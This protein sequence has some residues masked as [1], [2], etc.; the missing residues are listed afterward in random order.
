MAPLGAVAPSCPTLAIGAVAAGCGAGS[1]S[2]SG[3]GATAALNCPE[4]VM[5]TLA[6]VMRRVYSQGVQS[7]RTASAEAM[8]ERSQ[9]L[10]AAV[11]AGDPKAARAA[12]KALIATGH[13]TNLIVTTSAGRTLVSL[14]GPALTPLRGTIRDGAGK[15]IATYITSVWADSGVIA[16][17]NGITEGL[18]ALRVGE[19]S[20]AGS[21]E[22]PSGPLGDHGTLDW[23]GVT[24]QYASLPGKTFPAGGP[25]K[26]YLLKT[27]PEA[28]KLCGATGEDTQVNVL[29]RIANRIYDAE[30]G[31]RTLRQI[32]RVQRNQA[33]LRAVAARDPSAVKKASEALL[34]H[35]LVRLRVS[36]GG[37]LLYDLGGPFVLGP[38]HA[39]LRLHGKTIGTFVLSI[40]DDE[41]YLRLT[42]RL[43]GLNVL[44]YMRGADGR[45]RLVKNSLG[46]GAGSL[47]S[48]PARGPYTFR[49]HRYRVFTV[50]AE[51]FPSGPLTIRVLVP[52][53]YS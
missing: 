37:R 49:G 30:H 25:V 41:G 18:V 24:Y 39:D 22:L 27:V 52:S 9:A 4:T 3:A 45:P 16:E 48:V 13:M 34:H 29:E 31:P 20:I 19:R 40:Q 36:A 26:I 38:V 35:H 32:R 42:R 10:R 11:Q 44:M 28:E 6:S 17:G 8:I 7:E 5:A 21:A 1:A 53:P 15:P 14:G 43:V 46:P 12:A 23:H 50:D 51:A 33:L 47:A 2:G